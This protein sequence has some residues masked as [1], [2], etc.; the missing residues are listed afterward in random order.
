MSLYPTPD[1]EGGR[2]HL[3]RAIRQL[4]SPEPSPNGWS[5]LAARLAGEQALAQAIAHLPSHKPAANTWLHLADRLDQLAAPVPLRQPRQWQRPWRLSL[6]A[7]VLLLLVA[8]RAW[9]RQ[10]IGVSAP[11]I[12]ETP[13][14]GV[15]ALPPLPTAKPLEAEGEAFIEA[16]C[17]SL[18]QVCESGEFQQLRAQLTALQRQEQLLRI[19]TQQRGATPQLVR[20]QVRVTIL[21]ATV[22]REL[23]HLLTS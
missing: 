17:T 11:A 13:P 6:A 1:A 21:K 20:Q 10:P 12:V 9:L 18:P 3:G 14:L 8:G 7:T 22:T 5:T 4:P 15:P 23:I 19:Q 16:H 2:Q